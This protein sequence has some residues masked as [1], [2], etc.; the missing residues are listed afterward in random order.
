MSLTAITERF[1]NC[2]NALWTGY[3]T[4]LLLSVFGRV[5]DVD[6]AESLGRPFAPSLMLV[7]QI[8]SQDAIH[9]VGSVHRYSLLDIE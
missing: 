1:C 3:E 4:A 5:I 9:V 8:R 2:I 6:E 7:A